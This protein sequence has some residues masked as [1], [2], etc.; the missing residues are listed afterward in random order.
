MI[1]EECG[2]C[3][4][5]SCHHKQ[6]VATSAT[7]E[8]DDDD[9]AEYLMESTTLVVLRLS[10]SGSSSGDCLVYPFFWCMLSDNVVMN[11]PRGM[12]HKCRRLVVVVVGTVPPMN[13]N[14]DDVVAAVVENVLCSNTSSW[15]ILRYNI[16]MYTGATLSS[17]IFIYA[18]IVDAY[19]RTNEWRNRK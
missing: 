19:I 6:H 5:S 11:T 16:Y 14:V 9:D 12:F 4:S 18:L 7:E 2:C 15:Y 10:S 1:P 3:G 8:Y 13:D 17:V